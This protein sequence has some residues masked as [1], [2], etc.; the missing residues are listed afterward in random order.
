MYNHKNQ[1]QALIKLNQKHIQ[2]TMIDSTRSYN[3]T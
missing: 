1:I 3:I 2:T